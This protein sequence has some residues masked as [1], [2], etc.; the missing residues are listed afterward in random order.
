[1]RIRFF[2]VVLALFAA[3][4]GPMAHAQ[5]QVS[6][7]NATF[8]ANMVDGAPVDFRQQF[9]NTAPVVYYSNSQ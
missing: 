4:S 8:T 2:A 5:A 6:V 3:I 9:T 1:M 7:A